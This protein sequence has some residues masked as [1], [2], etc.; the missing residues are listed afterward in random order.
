MLLAVGGVFVLIGILR[1][2]AFIVLKKAVTICLECIGI[3]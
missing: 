1:G 2:E 3:G